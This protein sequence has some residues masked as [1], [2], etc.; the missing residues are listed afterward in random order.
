VLARVDLARGQLQEHPA[1]RIAVL[2]LEEQPVVVED[3][4]DGDGAGMGDP[5]AQ[6]LVAVGQA[7]PVA[8]DLQQF[9]VEDR[10]SGKGFLGEV[11]IIHAT[12]MSLIRL[13]L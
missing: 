8:M 7:H 6:A 4:D 1:Q 13:E 9:S 11:R 12:G 5:L 2:A 10:F 3:G